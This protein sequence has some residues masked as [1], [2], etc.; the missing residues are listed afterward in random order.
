MKRILFIDDAVDYLNILADAFKDGC[1]VYKA[2]GVQEALELLEKNYVD[3]VCSDLY[4]GDGTGVDL[5]QALKR[6]NLQ[7]PF[8]LMSGS[9]ENMDVRMAKL[10]GAIFVPKENVLELLEKIK[11][12]IT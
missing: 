12:V 1:E 9:E 10:Y 8:I 6:K 11:E 3:A 7:I 5:L 4:M 2:T